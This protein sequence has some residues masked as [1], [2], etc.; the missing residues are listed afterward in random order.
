MKKKK[1]LHRYMELQNEH[2]ALIEL[3]ATQKQALEN[4]QYLAEFRVTV[5]PS[6]SIQQAL[7]DRIG[8]IRYTALAG[9]DK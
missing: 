6:A 2:L 1:L 5:P 4:I 8:N 3:A 7:I 9:L